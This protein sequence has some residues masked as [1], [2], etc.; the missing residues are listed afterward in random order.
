[1]PSNVQVGLLPQPLKQA[2]PSRGR[3]FAPVHVLLLLGSAS[4][5]MIETVQ[6]ARR[7]RIGVRLSCLRSRPDD[8]HPTPW[9]QRI[10]RNDWLLGLVIIVVGTAL[11]AA[12][13]AMFL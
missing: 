8:W 5:G 4:S 1:M 11:V 7:T 6:P 13:H 3:G 12:M 2:R 10:L 9:S